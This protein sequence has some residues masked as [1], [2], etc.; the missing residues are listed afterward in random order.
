MQ[1][2]HE[3]HFLLYVCVVQHFAL[4]LVCLCTCLVAW[5]CVCQIAPPSTVQTHPCQGI[6][7]CTFCTG[8]GAE[9]IFTLSTP[10]QTMPHWL[11]NEPPPGSPMVPEG[12]QTISH[13]HVH[14]GLH[15]LDHTWMRM[16]S[17]DLLYVRYS[18]QAV[19]STVV[20]DRR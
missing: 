18:T 8:G 15:T 16:L 12:Q 14:Q 19:S 7:F 13:R 1:N 9:E 6:T 20:N 11:S 5:C 17:V 10:P 3:T 4:A 2:P